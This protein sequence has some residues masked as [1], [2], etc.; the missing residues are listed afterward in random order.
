MNIVGETA[1]RLLHGLELAH[2]PDSVHDTHGQV[3]CDALAFFGSGGREPAP[4]GKHAAHCHMSQRSVG[5]D[6]QQP[7]EHLEIASALL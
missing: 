3:L 2:E 7:K 6:V 1:A 4:E 5:T